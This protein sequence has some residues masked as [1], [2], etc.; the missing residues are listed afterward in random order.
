VC[1]RASN[2]GNIAHWFQLL[3]QEGTAAPG[4]RKAARVIL[5]G[6]PGRHPFHGKNVLSSFSSLF[7]LHIGL[8]VRKS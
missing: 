8:P 7:C 1:I 3:L 2:A 4:V 5:L 6:T